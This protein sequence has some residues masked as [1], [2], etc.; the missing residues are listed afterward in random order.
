M[1][2]R[3][4]IDYTEN[5][6]QRSCHDMMCRMAAPGVI[7]HH[8]PNEEVR[9]NAK[10]HQ[11]KMGMVS[12]FPDWIIFKFHTPFFLEFKVGHTEPSDAQLV[13][14]QRAEA[15]GIPYAIVRTPERFLELMREWG[16]LNERKNQ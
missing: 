6:L 3:P 13:F 4:A 9:G 8:S 1:N 10:Y 11:A 7:W 2:M 14:R 15:Q 12:G 5:Q 16:L